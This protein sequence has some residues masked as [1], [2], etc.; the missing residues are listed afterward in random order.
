MSLPAV[1]ARGRA[2][3]LV[4]VLCAFVLSSAVVA[5]R[6]GSAD[7]DPAA[8]VRAGDR[9]GSPAHA[10]KSLTIIHGIGYDGQFYYRLALDPFTKTRTAFGI[11]LD[12]PA[13]R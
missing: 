12:Q 4:P 3:V 10:P 13:R 11:T 5:L 8:F 2:A 9:F 6:L 1:S 7:W